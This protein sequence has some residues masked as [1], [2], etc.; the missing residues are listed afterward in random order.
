LVTRYFY[1]QSWNIQRFYYKWQKAGG[2][3]RIR[4]IMSTNVVA[5]DEKTSLHDARK[6][7][8]THRIRRALYDLS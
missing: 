5:V 2:T 1:N 4:D 8:E 6:I 7:M 3:M